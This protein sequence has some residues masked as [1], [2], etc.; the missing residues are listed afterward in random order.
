MVGVIGSS[1]ARTGLPKPEPADATAGTAAATV[2]TIDSTVRS[3][4]Q[5]VREV[6]ASV[7]GQFDRARASSVDRSLKEQVEASLVQNEALNAKEIDVTVDDQGVVILKGEV[8]T[9]E[10]K[11]LAVAMTR[12]LR[13][14]VRVEDNLA[15]TPQLRVFSA[16]TTAGRG[17]A[18]VR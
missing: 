9:A 5:G 2:G 16:P 15:I 18:T 17:D 1:L 14:V 8:A 7:Q 4:A 3:V 13:G 6:S 12:H 11:E 10:A